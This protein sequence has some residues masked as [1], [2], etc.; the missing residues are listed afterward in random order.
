M[1]S[2]KKVMLFT[3]VIILSSITNAFSQIVCYSST[4]FSGNNIK[5]SKSWSA[6]SNMAWNDKI[7]SIKV[8]QGWRVTLYEHGPGNGKNITITKDWTADASWR[9]K[10]SNMTIT[11]NTLMAGETL[12]AGQ[13]LVSANGRY[14]LRM[15]NDDGNL[16]VYKFN[17]GKQGAFV[18][19][20]MKYGFKNSK[21]IMQ[22]D[23][24]LVVYDGTNKPRWSTS[25]MSHFNAKWGQ[26][27]YKPVKLVLGDDGK[28]RLYNAAGKAVWNN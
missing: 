6:A 5:I 14:I 18:W 7:N 19:G 15:Q 8:P 26:A 21:L 28:L 25:T 4:N 20:S 2:L 9:N 10:I 16:C 27:A 13:K 17:N 1:N 11:K 22:T 24:N 23:G 12:N 3:L